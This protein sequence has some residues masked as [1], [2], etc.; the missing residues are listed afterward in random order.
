M[1]WLLISLFWLL[2]GTK[3]RKRLDVVKM[4]GLKN[5]YQCSE[6][7]CREV[8]RVRRG[9]PRTACLCSG[10]FLPALPRCAPR[11]AAGSVYAVK[12]APLPALRAEKKQ[13]AG[14]SPDAA[15]LP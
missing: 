8:A 15:R 4:N 7:P 9:R 10:S 14:T 6:K 13:E 1:F 5:V 2:Q 12:T 11:I 3:V